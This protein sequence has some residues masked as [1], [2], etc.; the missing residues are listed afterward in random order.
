VH[1]FL[2][3]EGSERVYEVDLD[4]RPEGRQGPIARSLDGYDAYFARWAQPWERQ[5]M[6][7]ARPAGGDPEVGRRFLATLAPHLW[8]GLTAEDHRQLR[9]IKARVEAE[10]IPAG[11]DPEFHLKLGPGALADVEFCTQVLQLT[12][13]LPEAHTLAAIDQLASAGHLTSE[14]AA[15]LAA[16]HRFCERTRNRWFLVRGSRVESLPTGEDLTRLARSLH[17]TGPALR[18]EYR[19]LTRRARRVVRRVFAGGE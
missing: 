6:V 18:E 17:T 4:L 15:A 3:G 2:A 14:E 10:R 7:R 9:R 1:R 19:R 12:H 8:R 16:A 5:A 11:E 13:R